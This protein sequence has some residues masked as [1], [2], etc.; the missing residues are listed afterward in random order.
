MKEYYVSYEQAV[1]LKELGFGGNGLKDY[2][3]QGYYKFPNGN[4]SP[5]KHDNDGILVQYRKKDA[6][7]IPAPRLD[8]AAAWLREERGIDIVISPR[9][10]SKTGERIGYFWR[11]SQR[12]DVID[13][14]IYKTYE[15][16]LSAAITKIFEPFKEYYEKENKA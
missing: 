8:Q 14:K 9:F 12:A 16:A 7:R 6:E 13:E 11:W 1:I 10:N 2:I 3:Y 4:V 15:K 5:I